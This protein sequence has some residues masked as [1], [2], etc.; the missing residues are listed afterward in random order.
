MFLLGYYGFQANVDQSAETIKGMHLMMSWIPAGFA[1]LA[2]TGALLYK[3]DGKT[4]REME[5]AI[6]RMER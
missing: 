4:E 2:A 3:I 1:L 5:A 6:T